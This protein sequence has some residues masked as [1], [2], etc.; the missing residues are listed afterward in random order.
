MSDLVGNPK[1]RFSRVKAQI[2][3]TETLKRVVE[4]VLSVLCVLREK[5][6]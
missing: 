4:K 3:C 2:G 5:W 1:D 6:R